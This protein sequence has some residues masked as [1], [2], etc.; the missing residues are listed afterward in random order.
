MLSTL[1][2]HG[3]IDS[4]AQLSWD[5]T[6]SD[7]LSKEARPRGVSPVSDETCTGQER[8]PL[9]HS[10]LLPGPRAPRVKFHFLSILVSSW[11]WGIWPLSECPVFVEW[12]ETDC[13]W[14]I[15]PLD[16]HS[17]SGKKTQKPFSAKQ[18]STEPPNFQMPKQKAR[19]EDY[20]PVAF[21]LLSSAWIHLI[22]F[23]EHTVWS[24]DRT[25]CWTHCD[26]VLI[27]ACFT[28]HPSAE[29]ERIG[30]A[31][32]KPTHHS[33]LPTTPLHP[34]DSWVWSASLDGPGNPPANS[35]Q[36]SSWI[37]MFL[38]PCRHVCTWEDL[39]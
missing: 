23:A 27:I 6:T 1:L 21:I 33:R 3:D 19:I 12:K 29:G 32:K 9:P 11:C 36:K 15:W 16:Q 20:S 37:T 28:R 31:G 4:R 18:N 2:H 10:S 13:E 7:R 8:V 17:V 25:C 30:E 35:T 22:L 39:H 34:M 26:I 5:I 14:S 24:A 38:L